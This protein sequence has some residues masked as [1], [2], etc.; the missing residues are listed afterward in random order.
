MNIV[1]ECHSPGCKWLSGEQA[2]GKKEKGNVHNGSQDITHI[3]YGD[4]GQ[5][6]FM[7]DYIF[8]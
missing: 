7:Q 3:L 2:R 4:L 1:L 8:K 5:R 6:H